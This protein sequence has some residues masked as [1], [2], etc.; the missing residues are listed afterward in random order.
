MRWL[1]TVSAWLE[2]LNWNW[3]TGWLIH[4]LVGLAIVLVC[5][6]GRVEPAWVPFAVALW[7]GLVHE[8]ADGDFTTH[9]AAPWQGIADTLAFLPGPI[10]YWI[11][12]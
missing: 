1:L 6:L 3:T 4:A 12:A 2:T 7:T 10:A 5:G 11:A 9:P 8:W